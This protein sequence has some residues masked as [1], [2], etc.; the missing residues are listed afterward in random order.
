MTACAA[1][2]GPTDLAESPALER[3][4]PDRPT[5]VVTGVFC[6]NPP[7]TPFF[8]RTLY[9]PLEPLD[10]LS[11]SLM[12]RAAASRPGSPT[13]G[14]R[15]S[16]TCATRP[17]RATHRTPATAATR[18]STRSEAT[19][20]ER[21]LDALDRVPTS[22]TTNG[23]RRGVAKPLRR[24]R[25]RARVEHEAMC[26]RPS[27]S[28][29]GA[30]QAPPPAISPRNSGSTPALDA[31]TACMGVANPLVRLAARASPQVEGARQAPPI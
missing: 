16:P 25:G 2:A 31:R 23:S 13:R 14:R 29:C 30:T 24:S 12:R 1:D 28:T 3:N 7:R 21:A 5:V 4:V 19:D 20:L 18:S 15:R 26:G 9:R 6:T 17:S 22:P 8:A 11:R 10:A 27:S